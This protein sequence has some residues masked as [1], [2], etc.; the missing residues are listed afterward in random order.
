MRWIPGKHDVVFLDG[1]LGIQ[2]AEI[3]LVVL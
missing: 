3:Q 2:A 1:G